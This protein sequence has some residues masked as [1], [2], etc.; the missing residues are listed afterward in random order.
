MDA[1]GSLTV[2]SSS[3]T[4]GVSA[5]LM[6][7]ST[8]GI[9]GVYESTSV[10]ATGQ[11]VSSV[12]AK[13]YGG[14]VYNANSTSVRYLKLYNKATAPTVGT[15][16]QAFAV[17]IP[18][19]SIVPLSGVIGINFSLGIGIGATTGP[20]SSNSTAPSANEVHAV[21]LYKQ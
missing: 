18:P 1:G 14:W 16:A 7:H 11:S 10:V 8:G 2:D 3:S 5:Y 20:E 21:I 19:S 17:P 9:D 4:A 15:D 6:A 13:F 12:P